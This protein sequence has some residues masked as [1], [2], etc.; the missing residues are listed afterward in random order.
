VLMLWMRRW[1][2]LAIGL[3][4]LAWLL[5][6]LGQAL[7]QRRGPTKAARGMQG[8][9]GRIRQWRENRGRKG[10]RTRRGRR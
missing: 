3:P 7:E 1:I 8:A 4:L 10:R 9:A 6:R 2:L 5:D